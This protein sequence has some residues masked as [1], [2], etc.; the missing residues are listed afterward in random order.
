M[1]QP[2]ESQSAAEALEAV[3]KSR[4]AVADRLVEGSWLYDLV[5]GALVAGMVGSQAFDQPLNIVITSVCIF[6]LLFLMRWWANKTGVSITGLNP[7]RARWVAIGLGVVMAFFLVGAAAIH[8]EGAPVLW[9][10]L[11]AVGGG[12]IAVAASRLWL[13]VFIAETRAR[14]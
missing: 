9:I 10:G 6:G 12:I 7:P 1:T 8:R 4:E 3:R 2:V 14:P 5:Y 13:K 11:L